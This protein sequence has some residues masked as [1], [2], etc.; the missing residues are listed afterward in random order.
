MQAIGICTA[1]GMLAAT[2]FGIIFVP[3]LYTL[4]QKL[5]EKVVC[6]KRS[7]T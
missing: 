7:G 5:R 4:F 1:S 2:L 3:S 6:G